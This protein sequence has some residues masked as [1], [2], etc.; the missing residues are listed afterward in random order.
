MGLGRVINGLLQPLGIRVVRTPRGLSGSVYDQDGLRTLHNHEFMN[1]PLFQRAYQ[2]GVTA[3]GSD[4]GW[5]WR[6]HVGLWVAQQAIRVPG[7][8]VECGVNA[9]FL[10]SA[11]MEALDWNAQSRRFFLLDTF[12]GLDTEQISESERKAGLDKKNEAWKA[13]GFYVQ[14]V[15][16]VR[17]N[18]SEWPRA[19]IVQGRIPD[20]LEAIDSEQLAYI[21]ID[22]NCA[23]PEYQAAK[24][25]WP[26][27]SDGGLVLLDDYAYAGYRAQKLKM[28]EF[29]RELGVEILSLP[30]GQGLIL[31]K[32]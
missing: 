21:H 11:I 23:E 24:A 30:T 27:L 32:S 22:L 1:E 12:E 8:F 29:A 2:R 16:G 9:G 19:V 10:S 4:Y 17:Q 15:E 31:K 18:F 25:L 26:K 14:G 20:T 6:V 3:V 28:D 5:H 13:S 7:D